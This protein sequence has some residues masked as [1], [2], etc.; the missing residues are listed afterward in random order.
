MQTCIMPVGRAL[1]TRQATISAFHK[2]GLQPHP[3][4]IELCQRL[5][6]P[7]TDIMIDR[8]MGDGPHGRFI[9]HIRQ[10]S[11]SFCVTPSM[12]KLPAATS[13]RCGLT[14]SIWFSVHE[15]P[16][17]DNTRA[18]KCLTQRVQYLTGDRKALPEDVAPF[19]HDQWGRPTEAPA[20]QESGWLERILG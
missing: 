18:C 12:E 20:K 10:E 16:E 11:G 8:W 6:E 17:P 13:F 3:Q 9:L 4:D 14:G 5:G 19:K 2:W 1:V 7:T 15:W